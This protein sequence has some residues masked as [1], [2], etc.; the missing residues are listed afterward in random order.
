MILAFAV[1]ASQAFGLQ[2]LYNQESSWLW[3]LRKL[4]GGML[5]TLMVP[6]L[7]AYM[8]YSLAENQVLDQ[9]LQQV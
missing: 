6:V 2:E 5:G 3:Q 8:S 1:L 4:S 9:D 7:S